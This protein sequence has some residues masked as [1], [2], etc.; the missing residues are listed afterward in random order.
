M[1]N[2][3]ITKSKFPVL[4]II[5][6]M[7]F[8]SSFFIIHNTI[9]TVKDSRS[10]VSWEYLW[11]NPSRTV[12]ASADL[13]RISGS[14]SWKKAEDISEIPD[15]P[16]NVTTAWFR[17]QVNTSGFGIPAAYFEMIYAQSLDIYIGDRHVFERKRNWIN[18]ENRLIIPLSPEDNGKLLY[19]YA[20]GEASRM[21]F[22]PVKS[23]LVG[24]YNDLQSMVF[25]EGF[26]S[27]V[28]GGL[29]V[30]LG[31][32]A[33]FY[34]LFLIKEQKKI[35]L[36]LGIVISLIGIIVTVYS[37]T[38]LMYFSD[39][40]NIL[41]FLFDVALG[42]F[43][44]AIAYFFEQVFGAGYKSY[45]RHLWQGMGIYSLFLVVFDVVNVVMNHRFAKVYYV[46]SIDVMGILMFILFLVLM[47][48]AVYYAVRGNVEARIMA[49]GFSLFAV[50]SAIELIIFLFIN[51]NYSLFLW[52]WGMLGFVLSL[53]SIIVRRFSRSHERLLAYASELESKN[54]EIKL[55]KDQ[56][57]DMNRYL[58]DRVEERTRQLNKAN[59]DLSSM[60]KSLHTTNSELVKIMERLKQ[61]QNQLIYSEKMAALG[62][63]VASVAHEM[64][65]PLGAIQSST[66]TVLGSL[67]KVLSRLPLFFKEIS[68]ERQKDFIMLLERSLESNEFVSTSE[69]RKYKKALVQQIEENKTEN[70]ERMAEMLVVMG[71]YDILPFKHILDAPDS[72]K[73]VE[74]AF[75]L[76]GI[77]RNVST[78]K[79]STDR[80]SK[81]VFALRTY[82]HFD[83][84]GEM[85]RTDIRE[86]IETVLM[87]FNNKIRYNV[88]VIRKYKDISPVMCYP[89]KLSQVWI[90]IIHN[91]LQAM[92]FKGVLEIEVSQEDEYAVV[93][94]TDSGPGIPDNVKNRIFEPFFTTKLPGEGSGL[95]LDI[96][97]KIVDKHHG[98][99]SVDSKPGRTTFS[100][101]ILTKVPIES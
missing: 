22:G 40:E 43:L 93:S 84:G 53:I 49:L 31:I 78:I 95:G 32:C 36:S 34:S 33:L 19:I 11:G 66:E 51:P 27:T 68:D 28:L 59:E 45:M 4:A 14:D 13:E 8:L 69:E 83:N 85:V 94:I 39:Y 87:L 98:R 18:D 10:S 62:Q 91:A 65:S 80:T 63:L 6:F 57:S 52:Q 23:V 81:I 26:S 97:K 29:F 64:N 25:K 38:L 56:L 77:K 7:L 58:E 9:S 60:N 79:E 71:I 42:G 74:M 82:A 101:Y 99:I 50:S 17:T 72:V 16:G 86:G 44:T 88:E 48:T 12:N 30:I 20:T 41:I 55:S 35:L 46:F 61:T 70:A 47:S 75:T 2:Y 92:N 24:E 5:L 1:V 100:I 90:N 73:M 67:D 96:V 89:D 15:S 76:S 3:N 21:R 37:P 54:S